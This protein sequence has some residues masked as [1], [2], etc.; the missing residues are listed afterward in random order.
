M[1]MLKRCI[2]LALLWCAFAV[3][4]PNLPKL[5]REI[6]RLAAAGGGVVG[7]A[8][9]HVESGDRAALNPSE[10]FPMASTY[11]VP[12]AV[13][14]LHRVDRGEIKLDE[15]VTLRP[16]DLHPGSGT[17]SD[18]F[19]KPGVALSVRNLLE[20]MMLISDNSA[21]DIC[22]RLAGGPEAVNRRLGALGI[23][24]IR[25]DRPT[26][27]LIMDA[28]GV[29]QLPPEEEWSPE[30]FTRLLRAV[31]P[32]A[33]DEARRRFEEDPRDTAT[34]EGMARLLV[35]IQKKDCLAPDSGE[36]LVDIMRRC[37]TGAAR[38][39]GMLPAGTAVAN[40]TGTIARSTNDV[41]IISLPHGAG[42]V[43]LAVFVKSSE[44]ELA[45]RERAIAEIAR[46]VHDYFVFR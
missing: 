37:R 24:G 44:K 27:M 9:I 13:Q 32:E 10:R 31:S 39:R 35:R 17:L 6:E 5:E 7:A 43:A 28:A 23:T 18:L 36:L 16:A 30:T 46:A 34:P 15:M 40:K 14:L 4:D 22:L 29:G 26:L 19:N 21:T 20:L 1:D 3:A 2:P 38:L 8:A 33:R 41:G 25:V 11:K 42:H 45:Q 12:I